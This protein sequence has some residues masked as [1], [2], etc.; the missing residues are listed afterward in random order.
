MNRY[1]KKGGYWDAQFENH[2]AQYQLA[3]KLL[4]SLM[5]LLQ[6]CFLRFH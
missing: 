6:P 2:H 3:A 4:L 1:C 5:L